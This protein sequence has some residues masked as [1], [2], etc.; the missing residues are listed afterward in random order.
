MALNASLEVDQY[1]LP[2]P[3]DLVALLAG[4][5]HFSK[6]DL[7]HAYQ[8]MIL[9]ESSQELVTINTHKGLYCY[10]HLPF[11]VASAPA[12]FQKAMCWIV[13]CREY[14]TSFAISMISW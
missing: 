14:P 2:W 11:G 13:S 6:I 4:G 3:E 12:L 5:Q 10:N 8:Q 1:P 7:S 9:E